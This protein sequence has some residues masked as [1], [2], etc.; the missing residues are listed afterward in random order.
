M[1]RPLTLELMTSTGPAPLAPKGWQSP[2]LEKD[3]TVKGPWKNRKIMLR[4]RNVAAICR[5]LF[6][7]ILGGACYLK[8]ELDDIVDRSDKKR[9]GF[10]AAPA[11]AAADLPYAS[12][13]PVVDAEEVPAPGPL[14]TEIEEEKPK[15]K[16]EA[17]VKAE[18]SSGAWTVKDALAEVEAATKLEEVDRVEK[19]LPNGFDEDAL[20]FLAD[21]INTK[22]EQ[23]TPKPETPPPPPA[24]PSTGNK[25]LDTFTEVLTSCKT[26]FD[27]EKSWKSFQQGSD[28]GS[29][30]SKGFQIYKA[31]KA[32]LGA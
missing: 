2:M 16:P 5:F 6:S 20:E 31:R 12:N 8:E 13:G 1:A 14:V 19:R 11:R 15:A 32:E 21:V 28:D 9:P 18:P 23:I 29:L 30:L 26:A 24:K 17:Q 3:G 10:D 4:W 27:A 25:T 22:R 7:D